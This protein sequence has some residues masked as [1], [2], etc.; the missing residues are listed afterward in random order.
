MTSTRV[1]VQFAT[2]NKSFAAGSNF[3]IFGRPTTG[4]RDR[5]ARLGV[6][7]ERRVNCR[8]VS[9]SLDSG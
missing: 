3:V 6:P 9:R 5:V 1:G 8:A 4:G 2:T 7:T